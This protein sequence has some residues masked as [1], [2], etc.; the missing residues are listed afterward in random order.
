LIG[1]KGVEWNGDWS[2][3]SPLWNK[4]MKALVGKKFSDADDGS[5][6]ICLDDFVVQFNKL[7]TC[8]IFNPE[9]WAK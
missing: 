1:H 8:K 4:R 7:Y 6:W 3:K 2:D 5:F 9:I